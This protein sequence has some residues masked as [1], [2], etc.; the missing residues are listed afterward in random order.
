MVDND[1]DCNEVMR[2][3]EEKDM[4]TAEVAECANAEAALENLFQ[5]YFNGNNDGQQNPEDRASILSQLDSLIQKHNMSIEGRTHDA[6][7]DIS[8]LPGI[9]VYNPLKSVVIG[10]NASK[11]N[12]MMSNTRNQLQG[13]MDDSFGKGLQVPQQQHYH[14]DGDTANDA[15]QEKK[16]VGT[17]RATMSEATETPTK[18]MSSK[19]SSKYRGVTLHVRSGRYEAHIWVKEIRKQMYLG[20]YEHE[21]HAA[22]AYDIAALKSKGRN[23]KTNFPLEKYRELLDCIDRMTLDELVMAVR[24]QSQGFSRGSSSYRGVTKHPTGRWEARI[25][26]PGSKHVYL[27][28][29]SQ[30]LEAARVYDR[31][32]IRLRGKGAATNF[33]LLEYKDALMDFHKLQTKVLQGNPYFIHVTENPKSYEQWLRRGSKAFP[34]SMFVSDD[35]QDDGISSLVDEELRDFH[36]KSPHD[37]DRLDRDISPASDDLGPAIEAISRYRLL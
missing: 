30:E 23:T 6:D 35:P 26:I 17:K 9:S 27:G 31:A 2:T 1:Q 19:A 37:L 12:E 4:Q 32:L 20:G 34:K 29:Y 22:E 28:L 24:R 33:S 36:Q 21:E 10:K 15:H 3:G 16:L 5:Q 8:K 14:D 7:E 25:G 11:M 18:K 13:P